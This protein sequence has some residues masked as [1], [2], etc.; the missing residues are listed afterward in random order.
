MDLIRS[1]A[2]V[3][4]MFSRFPVPRVEWKQENMRHMLACLPL[5]GIALGGVNAL[6]WYL[7]RKLSFGTLLFAAGMTALPVLLTG[8]IHMDGFMDTVDA[9]SSHGDAEKK[10][11]ILKDS[12]A[13]AFAVLYCALYLLCTFALYAETGADTPLLLPV[14]LIPVMSRCLSAAASLTFPVYGGEGLL[15]TFHEA[16]NKKEAAFPCLLLLISLTVIG[17]RSFLTAAV[18]LIACAACLFYVYKMS[19]KQF[20]GMSGDLAG[21][22]LEVSEIVLLLAIILCKAVF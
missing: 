16:G 1:A 21:F 19:R 5:V 13:G 11:T 3:F 20:G 9:L 17:A 22:L 7:A 8:G 6:W 15:K 18:C 12:H 2:M 4:S 14:C 10:R